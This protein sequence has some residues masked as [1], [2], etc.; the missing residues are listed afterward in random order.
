M[1]YFNE[2]L[3]LQLLQFLV[4]KLSFDDTAQTRLAADSGMRL[5]QRKPDPK[6]RHDVGET[7]SGVGSCP[8]ST[9]PAR[10]SGNARLNFL[11]ATTLPFPLHHKSPTTTPPSTTTTTKNGNQ[12]DPNG[13]HDK[14]KVNPTPL[15][16]SFPLPLRNDEVLSLLFRIFI[17]DPLNKHALPSDLRPSLLK[18]ASRPLTPLRFPQLLTV[19]LLRQPTITV[20]I[21][22]HTAFAVL[23]YKL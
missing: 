6:P 12:W 18:F 13:D 23:G 22:R 16:V 3:L 8:G 1:R 14:Q 20:S 7:F 21:I 2:W 19:S 9:G 4:L 17:C 15:Y 11:H 5:K 10:S